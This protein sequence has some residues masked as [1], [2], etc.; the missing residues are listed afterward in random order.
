M[1]NGRKKKAHQESV[2]GVSGGGWEI[3]Y[4]STSKRYRKIPKVDKQLSAFCSVA[5]V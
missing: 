2:E 3:T 1:V 5:V 4:E